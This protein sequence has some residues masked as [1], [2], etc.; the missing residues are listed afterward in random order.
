[1][2]FEEAFGA[3]TGTSRLIICQARRRRRGAVKLLLGADTVIAALDSSDAHH[4]RARV[5]FRGA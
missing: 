2:S 5:V 1:M 3:L 4:Q